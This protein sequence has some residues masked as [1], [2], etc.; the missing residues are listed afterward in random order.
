MAE[1]TATFILKEPNTTKLAIGGD[2]VDDTHDCRPH[3]QCKIHNY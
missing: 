2:R 3:Q 1:L